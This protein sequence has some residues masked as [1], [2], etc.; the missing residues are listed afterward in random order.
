MMSYPELLMS[1]ELSRFISH[2]DRRGSGE[3]E[4]DGNMP[5]FR[6]SMSRLTTKSEETEIES[7]SELIDLT[8]FTSL[9]K[10]E[11]HIILNFLR[12]QRLLCKA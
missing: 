8:S 4:N 7:S 10:T 5:L 12:A 2:Q 6:R 3:R 1:G 11:S 9:K